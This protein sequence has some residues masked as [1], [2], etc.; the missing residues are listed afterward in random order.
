MRVSSIK[1]N[2]ADTGMCP[3]P[4]HARRI[5]AARL[6]RS[7]DTAR[8]QC[9]QTHPLAVAMPD[10]LAACQGLRSPTHAVRQSLHG[11][12]LLNTHGGVPSGAIACAPQRRMPTHAQPAAGGV[13]HACS[14]SGGSGGAHAASSATQ[15]S[16]RPPPPAPWSGAPPPEGPGPHEGAAR[17]CSRSVTWRSLCAPLSDISLPSRPRATP[18]SAASVHGCLL[19]PPPQSPPPPPPLLSPPPPPGAAAGRATTSGSSAAG[20]AWRAQTQQVT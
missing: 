2:R 14:P 1:L 15:T 18:A 5:P 4:A 3:T 13:S 12:H 17:D 10:K 19:P 9:N 20:H 16:S 11:P 6:P 7:A 8:L